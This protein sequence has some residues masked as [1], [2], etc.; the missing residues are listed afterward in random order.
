MPEPASQR[1][2]LYVAD[3]LCTW[4]WGFAPVSRQLAAAAVA[5][6]AGNHAAL[7][8][9]AGGMTAG[10]TIPL[11]ASE[12]RGMLDEWQRVHTTTG[13][14]F[15][16]DHPVDTTTIFNSGPASR[17]LALMGRQH[18]ELALDYL[19]RLQHAFFVDRRDLTDADVLTNCA[20]NCGAEQKS[21]AV[22]LAGPDADVAFEQD[23]ALSQQLGLR[24]FPSVALRHG[25]HYALL[26]VGYRPWEALAARIEQWLEL[27]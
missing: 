4:C 18:P 22:A 3:P 14:P 16:F 7:R 11:H 24:A 21:F 23:L 20:M 12:V 15:A 26:S 2:I 8:I 27:G 6:P 5:G 17:A 25:S 19:H 13:Q 9:V 10:R 1:E